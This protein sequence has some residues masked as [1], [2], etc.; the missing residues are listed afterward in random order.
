MLAACEPPRLVVRRLEPRRGWK[1][2]P[3]S[4]AW[5]SRE[6]LLFF[7]WRDVKVR[8]KQMALGAAWALIQPL[9]TMVVFSIFF[10]RLAHMPSDGIPY[11]L[12]SLC[13][14]IAWTYFSAAITAGTQSLAA[15]QH[16]ISKVY[17]P[18]VLVP[19]A[20]VAAPLVDFA[21]ALAIVFALTAVYR[22]PPPAS[23]VFLPAFLGLA[24]LTAVA[25]SL[26]LSA[27]SVRYR[28]VRYV[29]PFV[30]QLWMFCSPV[31]YPSSIVPAAWRPVYA[32][33]PMASVVEGFRWAVLGTPAPG[34]VMPL[35]TAIVAALAG[36]AGLAY[37]RRIEGTVVDVL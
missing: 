33:N 31:V 2:P 28:D 10:G 8:Y 29:I 1:W 20:S 11:P 17:F 32:L 14:V 7:V 27:L 12:F 4:E 19:L 9:M 16:I 35:V 15:Q 18:R 36:A 22:V 5:G 26:W 21:I 23:I 3:L 24:V 6:L 34:L 30:I 37:F 25:I 13:G